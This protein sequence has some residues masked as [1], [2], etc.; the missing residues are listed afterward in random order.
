MLVHFARLGLSNTVDLPVAAMERLAAADSTGSHGVAEDPESADLI[1]FPQCHML[2]TDW[3]LCAIR[4][5][6]LTRRFQEKVMV[7]DERDR[8][9]CAYPGVYV[10][11]RAAEFGRY[12]RPWS[13]FPIAHAN[14]PVEP[15]LLF[16]FMGSA[17][18]RCRADLF[19]LR[20]ADAVVERVHG[21]T[22]F[23]PK[24]ADF[25]ERRA[26]FQDVLSRSRF[27]LCP[28]GRGTS[29]IRLYETLAAGRVPVIIS[30][31]WVPPRGPRWESLSL[32]WPENRVDGLVEML[33]KR[34][35][36]WQEMS[37][38][39]AEAHREFFAAEVWFH[40]L[41]DLFCD[42]SRSVDRHQFPSNGI[43]G[44]AFLR[45]GADSVRWRT[46]AAL[47]RSAERV[48]QRLRRA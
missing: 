9:W 27:V 10:S 43:R 42:V 40:H 7:Y 30:D 24:S 25:E 11:M 17:S 23:D 4:K 22:F 47:R 13:Y 36:Y 21:F 29:S 3:R 26:R 34:D 15:D 5:H 41:M 37:E 39:A 28:R 20:H 1:V 45:V 2:P 35:R 46:R 48:L 6:P 16:S 19:Q 32:R 18:S 8:P 31:D 14:P 38:A 12:Q 44:R 33:E